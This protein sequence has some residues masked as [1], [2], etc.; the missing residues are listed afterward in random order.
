MYTAMSS[1]SILSAAEASSADS[2]ST[3]APENADAKADLAGNFI[4]PALIPSAAAKISAEVAAPIRI[5]PITAL[6]AKKQVT[7]QVTLFQKLCGII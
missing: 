7:L 6:L 2:Q 3:A 1:G 4:P 5:G